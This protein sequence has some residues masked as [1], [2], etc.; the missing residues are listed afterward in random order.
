MWY[1]P[2]PRGINALTSAARGEAGIA[3][4]R[5]LLK[6]MGTRAPDGCPMDATQRGAADT[7]SRAMLSDYFL[8]AA[9]RS[10][11]LKRNEGA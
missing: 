5:D 6:M 4:G 8:G 7:N 2:P 11:A 3:L 10:L 9:P 1:S